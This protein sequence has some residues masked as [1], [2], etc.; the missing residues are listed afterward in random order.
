MSL[1]YEMY[2]KKNTMKAM[3][4][5]EKALETWLANEF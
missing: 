4:I 3:L 2:Y 1:K 5:K